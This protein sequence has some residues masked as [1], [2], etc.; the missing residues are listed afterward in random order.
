MQELNDKQRRDFSLDDRKEEKLV[1]VYGDQI[2]MW[3]LQDRGHILWVHCLLLCL[4]KVIAHTP[5]YNTFPV[6]LQEDISGVTDKKQT[7][8]HRSCNNGVIVSSAV[9][10]QDTKSAL[11]NLNC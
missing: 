6:F 8:D 5:A 3:G 7:V 9:I 10:E 11:S 1:P 2:V 4:E